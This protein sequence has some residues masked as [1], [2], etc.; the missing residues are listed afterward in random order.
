MKVS[1]AASTRSCEVAKLESSKEYLNM[2]PVFYYAITLS[3]FLLIIVLSI[4]VG[5]VAIF[6]GLIGATVGSFLFFIGPGSFYIISVHKT[7]KKLET[8]LEEITYITSWVLMVIGTFS[9]FSLNLAV[10]M[11]TIS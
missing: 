6:F 1:D 8:K 2:K 10:I 11:N 7:N 4:V 3:T 5:D 9:L